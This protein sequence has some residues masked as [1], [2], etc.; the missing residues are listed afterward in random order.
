LALKIHLSLLALLFAATL[1]AQDLERIKFERAVDFI[2]YELAQTAIE[3]Q[4]GQP[5]AAAFKDLRRKSNY[6]FE[7]LVEFLK[8]R[9]PEALMPNLELAFAVETYKE[10]YTPNREAA[11]GILK[12]TLF[13]DPAL[14]NFKLENSKNF[15]AMEVRINNYLVQI[16]E[17]KMRTTE[18]VSEFGEVMIVDDGIRYN[19][20]GTPLPTTE[21]DTQS[22]EPETQP[23]P[24]MTETDTDYEPSEWSSWIFRISLMTIALAVLLYVLL[25]YYEKRA[26]AKV[27]QTDGD[28]VHP[29]VL[30]L[31]AEL[32]LIQNN[33]RVMR[34]TIRRLHLDLDDHEDLFKNN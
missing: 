15:E 14:L 9:K 12:V 33:N 26:R 5:H 22:T 2:N 19:D 1:N 32:K 3:G 7:R 25:P 18:T 23:E 10:R 20:D 29:S 17:L 24:E 28:V 21:I 6:N 8:T 11:Y 30:A 4:Q 34:Q 27:M 16:F 13:K 31:E